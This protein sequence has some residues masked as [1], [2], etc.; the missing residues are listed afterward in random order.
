MESRK[1]LVQLPFSVLRSSDAT[2]IEQVEDGI[3]SAIER[4]VYKAGDCLPT[5]R[6][7]SK[8]LKVGR[9]VVERAMA[10]LKK[11]NY[12]SA[13]PRIGIVVMDAGVKC[14]RG[15]V[16]I[17][18]TSHSGSYYPNVFAGEVKSRLLEAGYLCMQVSADSFSPGKPDLSALKA[19]LRGPVDFAI[20]LFG[21]KTVEK[22]LSEND[23]PFVVV[24]ERKSKWKSCC[25]CIQLDWGAS[26]P[27]FVKH[28]RTSGIVRV[29]QMSVRKREIADA[30]SQ[31]SAAGIAC[32]QLFVR[33]PKGQPKPFNVE[34]AAFSSLKKRL[35]KCEEK[36]MPELLFFTDDHLAAGA[37]WALAESGLTAPED[38]K[39]V[40]WAN[41]GDAPAFSRRL[42]VMELD[43]REHGRIVSERI[44]DYLERRRPIVGLELG[45]RY[46]KGET[47]V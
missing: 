32:E 42:T 41:R 34:E 30:R 47:F 28:C 15:S 36:G 22:C 27:A 13:R 21:S 46:I 29:L 24:G 7:M 14:W 4:G 6:Q 37:L 10:R 39:V 38:V 16:L 33:E 18:T 35:G 17:V 45:P 1:K 20:V 5:T 2:L 31:L 19:Y 9:V 8:A 40:S 12:V 26:I 25:G 44:L 11:R 23:V 3:R 43:P